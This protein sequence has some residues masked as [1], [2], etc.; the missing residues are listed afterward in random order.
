MENS[1][2]VLDWRYGSKEMRE[3]FQRATI[4]KRM[5]TV[6]VALLYAL[7][8]IGLVREEDILVVQKNIDKIN[9]SRVEELEKKLG[10][11][12]MALTVHLAELSG[13]SGKFIHF[14]ATSYDIVDTAN[15][16]I[17]RDAINIIKKKLKNIIIILME[18]AKK[19]Q[20]LVMIG[21]THGQHALPITL[22]F[23]FANYVYEF[24]RSLER[25]NDTSKR[26]LKIKMA[27]AVGTMAGWKDKGLEIEK[28]VSEYL[29]LPPHEISTQIAP[30]DGYAELVSDLAILASQ[31]DRFALEI[32]ELMRPEIL[33]LAEGSAESRVGSSTMPHKENPVTAEKISGLAKVLRGFVISELENIPLWHERDLTNSSSERIILSHSF[34]II[35][36][37]LE[38]MEALLRN[39]RVYPENMRKNLELTK[40]LIMAESLMINLTLANVPRHIAHEL[41]MKV[42]REAE[43]EGKSLLEAALD[44]EEIVKILGKE[45]IIEALNPYN[46]LGEY[47]ELISRALSY[48][49]NVIEQT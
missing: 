40:G 20:E 27:G 29:G 41:V 25:L 48:A 24:T 21:R 46:Y 43:R 42:S 45:K 10:H 26:L 16:L 44:N 23:K 2:C 7:S 14:G 11:D 34:L 5:A 49:K 17:F 36:E 3:L 30:R 28:Y 18:Y 39:L 35:D 33:E 4:L 8:K 13:E 38:S 15:I 32:R 1:I 6:E 19:Y 9:I 12:V 22:G 31:L 47:K 37:M